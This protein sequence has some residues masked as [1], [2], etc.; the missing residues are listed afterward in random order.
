[1]T[2]MCPNEPLSVGSMRRWL[3]GFLTSL[4]VFLYSSCTFCFYFSFLPHALFPFYVS[5]YEPG[6]IPL[7]DKLLA[8]LSLSNTDDLHWLSN[9]SMIFRRLLTVY[10]NKAVLIKTKSVSCVYRFTGKIWLCWNK[11]NVSDFL[12]V[13]FILNLKYAALIYFKTNSRRWSHSLLAWLARQRGRHL[14]YSKPI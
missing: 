3:L 2:I 7:E 12:P 9:Y 6:H 8:F 13:I 5:G 1:M 10:T 4:V 14:N 11:K